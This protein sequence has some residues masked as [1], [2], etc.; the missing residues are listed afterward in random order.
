MLVLHCRRDSVDRP[1]AL[2]LG[3]R[4]L[5]SHWELHARR[6][7]RRR[8][9]QR[10][11]KHQNYEATHACKCRGLRNRVYG[12]NIR[13]RNTEPL[14]SCFV[15]C[16]TEHTT[17]PDHRQNLRRRTGTPRG[18]RGSRRRAARRTRPGGG[19]ASRPGAGAHSSPGGGRARS[20]ARTAARGN[21]PV[22]I[23]RHILN[24]RCG[25][26]FDSAPRFRASCVTEC[27]LIRLRGADDRL[28]APV[29][30]LMKLA[31]A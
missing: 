13:S 20:G 5:G 15:D 7:S 26:L 3:A 18:A 19:R 25:T 31:A 4:Q 8:T 1:R 27:K 16:A 2:I 21:G 12:A 23:P 30:S 22:Q 6:G 17:R 24:R 14:S 28:G 29:F 11:Q 10:V 9:H